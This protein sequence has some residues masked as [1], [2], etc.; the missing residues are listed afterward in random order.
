[1][2]SV[3]VGEAGD[4]NVLEQH[5]RALKAEGGGKPSHSKAKPPFSQC[6]AEISAPDQVFM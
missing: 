6:G 5:G 1:M 4:G 2:R 3:D